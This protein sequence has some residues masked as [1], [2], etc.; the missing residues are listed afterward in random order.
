M[1]STY[2]LDNRIEE[3]NY[4][5]PPTYD[6]NDIVGWQ[7]ENLYPSEKFIVPLT[8]KAPLITSADQVG[9]IYTF[10]H[11]SNPDLNS[12]KEYEVELRCSYDPNDKQVSPKRE[13]DLALIAEPMNY[14]IR[15]QNTG[16]DYAKD[17]SIVDTLSE[18][19]DLSTFRIINTSHPDEL[20][21]SINDGRTVTF[22]FKNIFLPDSTTNEP[23]SNGFVSYTITAKEDI[24][25]EASIE[26]T[27]Y[28]YFDFNPAIITN[29][30]KS[31]MV[32]AF[33]VSR[34]ESILQH[35]VKVYPNPARD[36]INISTET[37]IN[38]VVTNQ[39]GQRVVIQQ[40]EPGV[41]QLQTAEWQ[42]GLYF[43]QFADAANS[44]TA[45]VVIE[46]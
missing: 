16:N 10:R 1:L 39:L 22:D 11:G 8:V 6:D 20:E 2:S 13:D 23:L 33:P 24:E 34:T 41:N 26:N 43:L 37:A 3:Y 46:R 12:A 19:L 5:V 40:L 4:A 21:V 31:I 38:L 7:I 44:F 27:A 15:F 18:H 42:S 29:T 35:S 25:Q 17:V 9:E 30:T 45:R 32:E 28:I 14:K 36:H